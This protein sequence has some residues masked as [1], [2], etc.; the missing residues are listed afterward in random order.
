[1]SRSDDVVCFESNTAAPKVA[2][3]GRFTLD[4]ESVNLTSGVY[5]FDVGAYQEA[6]EYAY[7]YHW[8]AY[9]LAVRSQPAERGLVRL[10]HRWR[11]E[12]EDPESL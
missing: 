9:Q 5:C 4:L 3:H 11:T 1:M 8:L 7:D 12:D 6:W 10:G 2:G